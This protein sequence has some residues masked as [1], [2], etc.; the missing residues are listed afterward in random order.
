MASMDESGNIFCTNNTT[1]DLYSEFYDEIGN[2][3]NLTGFTAKM[4]VKTSNNQSCSDLIIEFSTENGR[5][6]LGGIAGTI[7]IQASKA[8]MSLLP[9]GQY[10]YDFVINTGSTEIN[11][12]NE[13]KT[14]NIQ[15]GIT[16]I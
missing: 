16:T 3:I 5:I 8:D 12:F 15:G 14:F 7:I 10:Y 1:F 13:V 6:I 9:I 11:Y 4:Q 2:L